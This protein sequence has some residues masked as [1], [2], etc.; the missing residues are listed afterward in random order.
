M[1]HYT[2]STET[3]EVNGP[4]SSQDRVFPLQWIAFATCM[5]FVLLGNKSPQN[6]SKLSSH[7]FRGLGVQVPLGAASIPHRH[8]TPPSFL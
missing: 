4:D 3:S 1:L 6:Y 5:R 8:M 2:V 7:S